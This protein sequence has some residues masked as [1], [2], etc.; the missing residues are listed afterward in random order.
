M[1]ITSVNDIRDKLFSCVNDTG[2]KF[3]AMSLTPLNNLYFPGVVDT[4]QK[5]QKA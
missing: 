3:I 4:V 1:F 2:R 5:N